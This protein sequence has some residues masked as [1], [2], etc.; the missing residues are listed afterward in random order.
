MSSNGIASAQDYLRA[1]EA[2]LRLPSGKTFRVR[3]PGLKFRFSNPAPEDLEGLTGEEKAQALAEFYWRILC[4][5]CVQ[6]R[7]SMDPQEGELHPDRI[8]LT[9][10][11]FVI[12]W[13]GGEIGSDGADL[14]GFP[15]TGAGPGAGAGANGADVRPVAERPAHDDA[16]VAPV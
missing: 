1:Q 9:D 8:R 15:G 3:A 7:V 6:P 16:D 5:V 12:K 13:A 4:E 14:A 2:E 10:A 11:Q